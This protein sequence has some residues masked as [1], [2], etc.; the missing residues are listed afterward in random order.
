MSLEN[1]PN[2]PFQASSRSAAF[3]KALED[4]HTMIQ[5]SADASCFAEALKNLRQISTSAILAAEKTR[6]QEC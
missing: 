4:G 1:D 3:N 2:A 6:G 5:W